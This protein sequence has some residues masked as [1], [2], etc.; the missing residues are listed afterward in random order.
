MSAEGTALRNRYIKNGIITPSTEP[1]E[2]EPV[3]AK[4]KVYGH[5]RQVKLW[6]RQYQQSLTRAQAIQA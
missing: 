5:R 1:E 2:P 4:I 6:R 3:K